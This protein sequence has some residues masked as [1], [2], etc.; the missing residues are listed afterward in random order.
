V[1]VSKFSLISLAI[2]AV[3]VAVAMLLPEGMVPAGSKPFMLSAILLG[4]GSGIL[5]YLIAYNGITTRIQQFTAY[6]MG[7]MFL[8]M[9]IGLVGVTVVAL[10][11]KEYATPFV[12]A[13]FFCYFI[14]TSFEVVTLLRKL[15]TE[16]GKHTRRSLDD[17]GSQ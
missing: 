3:L 9:M 10:N 5:G 7:S 12:I 11:F 15:R 6:I 2:M 4:G 16:N 13:Y 1:K 14:F 17:D 8:K